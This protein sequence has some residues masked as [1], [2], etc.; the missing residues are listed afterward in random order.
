M[1]GEHPILMCLPVARAAVS[2]VAGGT[3]GRCAE[4][5]AA[6]WVS[7]SGRQ[8]IAE[9]RAQILCIDCV[10]KREP[11]ADELMP[12]NARQLAEVEAALSADHRRN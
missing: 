9:Q 1:T 7:P 3:R 2:P 5:G 11:A 12:P 8:I 4:C 10:A 6:V